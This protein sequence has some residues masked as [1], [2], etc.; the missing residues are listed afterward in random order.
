VCGG[1][2]N[3]GKGETIKFKA[4][5]VCLWT[6]KYVSQPSFLPR[7]QDLKNKTMAPCRSVLLVVE[8]L[9]VVLCS[10]VIIGM[11]SATEPGAS[12]TPARVAAS[13]RKYACQVHPFPLFL[14]TVQALLSEGEHLGSYSY[15]CIATRMISEPDFDCK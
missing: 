7:L 2:G 12:S 3:D 15:Y 14:T 8:Y 10:C 11:L 5:A 6:D 9:S 13:G 4:I 1:G